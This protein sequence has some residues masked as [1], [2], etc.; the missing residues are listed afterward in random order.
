MGAARGLA[1]GFSL[2][3]TTAVREEEPIM[4]TDKTDQALAEAG[5]VQIA[6]MIDRMF[7]VSEARKA[8]AGLVSACGK[9]AGLDGKPLRRRAAA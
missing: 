3:T 1:N 9:R 8:D 2:R 7:V 5:L 6:E 4:A